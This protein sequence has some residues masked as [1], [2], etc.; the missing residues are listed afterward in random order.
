MLRTH[1]LDFSLFY[2]CKDVPILSTPPLKAFTIFKHLPMCFYPF[3]KS[4]SFFYFGFVDIHF[5]WL[6]IYGYGHLLPKT[7]NM[8]IKLWSFFGYT[9]ILFILSVI[10]LI[11]PSH[12]IKCMATFRPFLSTATKLFIPFYF[13]EFLGIHLNFLYYKQLTG[14][15]FK[16][17]NI[18]NI[19]Q[20]PW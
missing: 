11:F 20:W 16:S 10:V 19:S 15:F 6:M 3:C 8:N 18:D 9:W 5:S 13:W 4:F 17:F 14:L 1:F 7:W 12:Y 2:S